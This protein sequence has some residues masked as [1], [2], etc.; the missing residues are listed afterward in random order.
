MK[1]T[2]IEQIKKRDEL[3]K[4]LAQINTDLMQIRLR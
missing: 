2:K 1:V 4:K 3:E